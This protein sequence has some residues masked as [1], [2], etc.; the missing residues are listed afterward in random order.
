MY[1]HIYI[2]I[3]IQLIT[4]SDVHNTE[5]SIIIIFV[6]LGA[7]LPELGEAADEASEA[8]GA[9]G[10]QRL[11]LKLNALYTDILHGRHIS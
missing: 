2:Y 8:P 1:T 11:L 7:D 9:R 6:V 10:V 3:Y 5:L 4:V